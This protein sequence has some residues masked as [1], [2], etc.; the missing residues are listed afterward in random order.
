MTKKIINRSTSLREVTDLVADQ[1]ENLKSAGGS[2]VSVRRA[3]NSSMSGIRVEIGGYSAD[4]RNDFMNRL[5]IW[6]VF[7]A[8]VGWVLYEGLSAT[9]GWSLGSS[10][11]FFLALIALVPAGWTIKFLLPITVNR[12]NS[13][14]HQ[15][16]KDAQGAKE[17]EEI[18][19]Q[20]IAALWT[21]RN[22]PMFGWKQSYAVAVSDFLPELLGKK[23]PNANSSAFAEDKLIAGLND[24]LEGKFAKSGIDL[25]TYI[26]NTFIENRIKAIEGL[27]PSIDFGKSGP[28]GFARAWLRSISIPARFA[29]WATSKLGTL[30][31]VIGFLAALGAVAGGF[32]R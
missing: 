14:V 32:A 6:A 8:A 7:I 2:A 31:M 16:L 21:L 26:K 19:S 15:A 3:F 12:W 18:C 29:N 22:L 1:I 17:F 11:R 10:F 4:A 24:L 27:F 13:G 9:L 25:S 30:I 5:I 20:I 28:T 23:K